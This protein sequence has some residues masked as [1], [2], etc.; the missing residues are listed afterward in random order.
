MGDFEGNLGFIWGDLGIFRVIR[1]IH[2]ENI[3]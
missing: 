3:K 2:L 1:V